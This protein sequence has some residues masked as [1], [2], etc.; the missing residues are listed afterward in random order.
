MCRCGVALMLQVNERAKT[1]GD[2][3]KEIGLAN[4]DDLATFLETSAKVPY[5]LTYSLTYVIH[6]VT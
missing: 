2:S 1:T 4:L 6:L 3:I 5:L